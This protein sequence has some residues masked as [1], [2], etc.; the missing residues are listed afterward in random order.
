MIRIVSDSACDLPKELLEEYNIETAPLSVIKDD[1]EYFDQI[2]IQPKEVYDGMRKG[3]VYKTAQVSPDSFQKKFEECAINKETVIYIGFSS[4]LSG[5]YQSAIIATNI[6]K[7]EHPDFDI[8]LID[9]KAASIGFGLIVLQAAK[10]VKNGASK[11]EVL[12]SIAY[13]ISHIEHIF[14]VDDLEYLYRGGRVNRTSAVIGGLLNIKPILEVDDE[15]KLVALEKVRGDSKVLKRMV[16]IMGERGDKE[17]LKDQLIG[18]SHGDDLE[19]AL[20]LKGM[21]EEK[22]GAKNFLISSVGAT[23][24]AH[25][26]PG[27]IALFFLHK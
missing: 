8:E 3:I 5:T 16:E 13:Y 17:D 26:G 21:I 25:S 9:T 15:G 22:Y 11:D 10:L 24:G 23:I 14:K 18:I 2:T 12:S 6:V 20:K 27:T 1:T 4:G 19:E 7:E